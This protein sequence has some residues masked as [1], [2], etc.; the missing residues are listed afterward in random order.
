MGITNIEIL[1]E[2]IMEKCRLQNL[3]K[4]NVICGRNNSGKATILRQIY[5]K[6]FL[7]GYTLTKQEIESEITRIFRNILLS[8]PITSFMQDKL[9]NIYQNKDSITWYGDEPLELF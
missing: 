2:E 4:I 9:L 6:N 8:E 3:G 5:M 1:D 7:N